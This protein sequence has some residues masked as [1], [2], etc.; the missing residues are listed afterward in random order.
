NQRIREEGAEFSRRSMWL[1][2][3]QT[4]FGPTLDFSM[5]M[6][7]VLLLYVCGGAIVKDPST[8]VTLGTFVAFQRYIQTMVWPMAAL[9]MAFSMYQRSVASSNRLKE[10]FGEST[11]VP[12]PEHQP[13]TL[14]E[15]LGKVEFRN[16]TFSFP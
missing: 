2:R 12:E 14:P 15:G 5:S 7:L 13:A 10:V 9:G 11:D 16:L 1:A 3:V 8:A 4:S 6:G